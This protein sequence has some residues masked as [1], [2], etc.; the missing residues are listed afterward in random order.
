MKDEEA[1]AKLK[2]KLRFL[3]VVSFLLSLY[4]LKYW[5]IDD[6][7][8]NNI[9]EKGGN[10]D[11]VHWIESPNVSD[12]KLHK[13]TA[14]L[15]EISQ[16]A[17]TI[18]VISAAVP[19][20]L[21][22]TN[23]D[24]WSYVFYL[25]L[26]A[27]TWEKIGFHVNVILV[28]D[29]SS[30]QPAAEKQLRFVLSQ[31]FE[32]R[33]HVSIIYVNVKSSLKIRFSQVLRMYAS[34]MGN[35][36]VDSFLLMS[37]SDLWP[38]QKSRLIIDSNRSVLITNSECCGNFTHSNRVYKHFPISHIGMSV[39]QW[40]ILLP[41]QRQEKQIER[42][43]PKNFPFLTTKGRNKN[44][45]EIRFLKPVLKKLEFLFG[46]S[47]YTESKRGTKLWSLDQK[48]ISMRLDAFRRKYSDDVIQF[49]RKW[50]CMR[51]DRY[52]WENMVFSD[53]C[54]ADAHL[55]HGEVWEDEQW[56]RLLH[57]SKLLFNKNTLDEFELY[58][59]LF[60]D[61]FHCTGK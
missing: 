44:Y 45:F 29:F 3:V 22:T 36:H 4:G 41:L 21:H 59:K 32:H 47:I 18:V 40:K 42:F 9:T 58:R 7:F 15:H 10:C 25:P 2:M 61:M 38:I 23:P 11:R 51:V 57:L 31:L 39:K 12:G 34:H 6:F 50:R 17:H 35:F 56:H 43:P 20:T 52:D 49:E 30:I 60:R 5:I 53:K 8:K 13:I 27:K 48:F 37:D 26:T 28:I 24:A 14:Y 54:K 1:S 33:K 46:E 16:N 19:N 55:L